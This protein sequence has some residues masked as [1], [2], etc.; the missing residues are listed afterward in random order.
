MIPYSKQI[1]E[2]SPEPITS[3]DP[4]PAADHLFT[5]RPDDER[6]LLLEEQAQAFYR[7]TAQLLFF[8]QRAR[9]DMQKLMS[10]PNKCVR[11][12]YKDEWGKLKR[13]LRY[14]KGTRHMKLNITVDSLTT[15]RW[16]VDASYGLHVECKGHTSMMR[17]LGA[18][19]SM[20]MSKAHKLNTKSSTEAELVGVY[21]ALSDV[22]WDKYFLEAQ[23]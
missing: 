16:Y 18:G 5:V 8:S 3:T 14:L 19:A 15:I 1:V 12:P 4:K 10:F 22:L 11:I 13:G 23:G 20:N 2:D 9:L 6:K 17:T 7:T 21:D